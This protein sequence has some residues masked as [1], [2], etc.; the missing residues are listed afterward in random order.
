MRLSVLVLT[1][2]IAFTPLGVAEDCMRFYNQFEFFFIASFVWM[3]LK[4][5]APIGFLD[6]DF[7][8][9]FRNA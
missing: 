7:G 4:A 1:H 6:F 9:V 8:A 2:V 3:V 5:F